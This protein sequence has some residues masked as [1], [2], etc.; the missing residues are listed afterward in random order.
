[1]EKAGHYEDHLPASNEPTCAS[2]CILFAHALLTCLTHSQL[3][4]W[5]AAFALSR[6]AC[7]LNAPNISALTAL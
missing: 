6:V 5:A 3:K 1:M 4:E 2:I 7:A